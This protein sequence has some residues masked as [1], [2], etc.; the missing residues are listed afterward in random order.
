MGLLAEVPLLALLD[1]VQL[2]VTRI[3]SICTPS[4]LF[5]VVLSPET[6]L[7]KFLFQSRVAIL[8]ISIILP[9]LGVLI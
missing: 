9:F 6:L 5:L 4:T 3:L 2:R 8:K 7:N 1:Q